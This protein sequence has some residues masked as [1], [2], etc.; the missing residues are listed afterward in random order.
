M[1]WPGDLASSQQ[2]NR[3][4]RGRVRHVSGALS[5]CERGRDAPMMEPP[6]RQENLKNLGVFGV[7]AV[8]S[9]PPSAR[10]PRRRWLLDQGDEPRWLWDRV[11]SSKM[12][13]AAWA[14][15]LLA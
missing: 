14:K 15:A 11:C 5:T 4:P 13:S 12:S 10:V 9:D 8:Q 7:L 2:A 6:S 1:A 3:A